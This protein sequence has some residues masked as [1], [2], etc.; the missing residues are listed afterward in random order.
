M[1]VSQYLT[2]GHEWH[3]VIEDSDGDL[4]FVSHRIAE[5]TTQGE[6]RLVEFI[7]SRTPSGVGY[8]ILSPSDRVREEDLC[9]EGCPA[10]PSKIEALRVYMGD[11][12]RKREAAMQ[13]IHF[14]DARLHKA[15]RMFEAL[16]PPGSEHWT[17][18]L[19]QNVI[20]AAKAAKNSTQKF[21]A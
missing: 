3:Q 10:Q 20:D 18:D 15:Q 2:V 5:V 6:R 7:G 1:D 14:C 12:V 9:R 4:V 13:R 21:G 16:C 17:T 8:G 19:I 11:I